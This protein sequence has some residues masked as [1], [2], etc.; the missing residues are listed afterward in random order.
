MDDITSCLTF[1]GR[2]VISGSTSFPLPIGNNHRLGTLLHSAMNSKDT[3][4]LVPL[5]P[6][7]NQ[8]TNLMSQV[9]VLRDGNSPIPQNKEVSQP[10]KKPK[11][12]IDGC[13][14]KLEMLNVFSQACNPLSV[15]ANW[16]SDQECMVTPP[17]PGIFTP[18]VSHNGF[19]QEGFQ[20]DPN[21]IVEHVSVLSSL[22]TSKSIGDMLCS[23]SNWAKKVD[24]KK[25]NSFIESGVEYETFMNV[26][27]DL[28]SQAHNYENP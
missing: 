24:I 20:R 8:V 4:L 27:V 13:Q 21:S 1:G 16:V 10:L 25:H 15:C 5:T 14:S 6:N 7:V 3:K 2:K 12:L 17:F 22:G 19:V 9:A 28:E 11:S 23:I 18:A 26:L